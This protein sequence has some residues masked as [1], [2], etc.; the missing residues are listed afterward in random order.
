MR[1]VSEYLLILYS[2]TGTISITVS[3]AIMA[4]AALVGLGDR[5]RT[6]RWR[7]IGLEGP[8]LAWVAAAALATLFAVEPFDSLGKMRKLVLFGMLWWAPAVVT[9]AWGL[10]RIYMAL[11]FSAGATSL[12]GVL[13]FF[14]QSG[15]EFSVRIN[16]FHG[17]YL[18]NSAMLLLCTFPAIAFTFCPTI[19]SSHRW[20]AGLAACSILAAQLL[21]RLP[22][23]WLGTAVGFLLL[24][25]RRRIPGLALA[26]PLVAVVLATA[27][28]VFREPTREM[29]SPSSAQNLQ[30]QEVW[31]NGLTLFA[32]DPWTGVGL[33]DL[34]NVYA[35]V[36]TPAARDEGHMGSVPLQIGV[37]MGVPGLLAFGWL[38]VATFRRLGSARPGA[39]GEPFLGSVVDGAEAGFAAFLAQG[40][41][42]WNFGDSEVLALLFFF[43]G[44]ALV[45]GRGS[46]AP[47]E[48]SP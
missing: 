18:T 42:E 24:A 46:A 22:G 29:L 30:R 32:R 26:I 7:R 19:R 1:R 17:F 5:N 44:T 36:K 15:P 40:L 16:G 10:G 21:G 39:A 37:S 34:R 35:T 31:A 27:P 6:I 8:V 33:Q 38:V 45:A 25:Y 11:L 9:G 4:L 48:P 47:A 2:L 41:I 14:F 28:G 13:I 20:G 12:Y 3:Q 23:A 43:V